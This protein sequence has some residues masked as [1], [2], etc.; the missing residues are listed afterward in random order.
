M[1]TKQ[2]I[3]KVLTKHWSPPA[4][5]VSP[6]VAHAGTSRSQTRYLHFQSSWLAKNKWLVYSQT[7]QGG[8]CK[9]CMLFA[10]QIVGGQRLG[11][12]VSTP[13]TNFRKATE[14]IATHASKNY[15]QTAKTKAENF[16][17]IYRS[18][19]GNVVE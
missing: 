8:F 14:L 19:A 13:F 4:G 11:T 7:K 17:E 5:F 3:Y 1:K 6:N 2:S 9:Y 16:L 12:F 15:H 18:S 10:N